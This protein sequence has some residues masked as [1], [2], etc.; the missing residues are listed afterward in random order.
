VEITS[1]DFDIASFNIAVTGTVS[2]AYDNITYTLL[3]EPT[4][5]SCL[6]LAMSFPLSH[7]RKIAASKPALNQL[8]S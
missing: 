8:E 6:L 1:P 2:T 5:I 4:P 3:P 7:R